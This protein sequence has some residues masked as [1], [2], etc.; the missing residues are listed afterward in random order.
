MHGVLSTRTG[1]N[2]Y[3]HAGLVEHIPE[4]FPIWPVEIGKAGWRGTGE[5]HRLQ[6][7]AG[8]PLD[9]DDR[10]VDI[11]RRDLGWSL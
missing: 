5:V 1:V 11:E 10:I 4:R 9:L 3:H 2:R 8:S 7:E 6:A